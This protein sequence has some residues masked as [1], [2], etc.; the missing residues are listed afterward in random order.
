MADKIK[1]KI[2]ELLTFMTLD[3]RLDLKS[4]ALQY[5]LGLTVSDEGK[6][7]VNST[8][9]LVKCVF[10]LL[11][12]SE[13][14]VSSTAHVT[15][16][17]LSSTDDIRNAMLDIDVI[18]KLLDLTIDPEWTHADKV[19]MILSNLTH[20]ERG[21]KEFVKALQN[22][23]TSKNTLHQLADIFDRKEYNKN[24]DFHYLATV[25]LNLSRVATVRDLFLNSELCV[26][27]RLLPYTQYA[28][29]SVRRGGVVGLIKNLSFQVGMSTI[30]HE[31]FDIVQFFANLKPISQ[32]G[33]SACIGYVSCVK[34]HCKQVL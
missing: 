7:L 19:C 22:D 11:L 32:N 12:D 3:S 14:A 1:D 6:K 33:V 31:Y 9:D 5:V 21:A 27:P 26:L 8:P 4:A 29:S 20:S 10:E 17:N 30:Q 13:P 2:Q 24:A 28:E 23:A 18:P 34:Y 25:F 15:I 16:L